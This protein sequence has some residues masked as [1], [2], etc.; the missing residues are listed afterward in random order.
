MN[1]ITL[2][3]STAIVV[4][5]GLGIAVYTTNYSRKVN[6]AFLIS[7]TCM[8]LWLLSNLYIMHLTTASAALIVISIAYAISACIPTTFQL[9]RITIKYPE[10]SWIKIFNTGRSQII[11]N[12]LISSSCF[13]PT[14][15]KSVS[16]PKTDGLLNFAVPEYGPPYI[17]FNIYFIAA[18]I[19]FA[20]G[21]RRD[22]SSLS[23][24]Q[25]IELEFLGFAC[26]AGLVVGLIFG[27]IFAL[28]LESSA[29][30]PIAHAASVLTLAVIVAY[31]ISVHKILAVAV[32][33]RTITAYSLLSC[34]LTAVYLVSWVCF[35]YAFRSLSIQEELPS[36]II[37]TLI[38]AF[39]MAPVR[40]RMQ[41][42]A[43][44][45]IATQAMDVPKAIKQAGN[46]FQS[47]TTI[48]AL[49]EQ[50]SDL[51]KTSLSAENLM[52]L[53]AQ[54][55]SISQTY[56]IEASNMIATFDTES[57]L[58]V[59]ISKD[60]EPVCIDSLERVRQ[61]QLH[62]GAQK[63]L[64]ALGMSIAIGF[65][66]KSDLNGIVM[67]GSR[68]G[69]RIYDR[70]EQE[71]LQILCNQFAVA[72]E[73]AQMYTEM[74]DSKIRNEILLDQLVSGVIVADTEQR[75]TLINHEA[76][77]VT[78]LTEEQA[79]GNEID[80]LPKSIS[81]VLNKTLAQK[82]GQRNL[83][84]AL[85]AQEEES[86]HVRMGSA[87]LHGHDGK[88]MGALLVFTDM[89]ELKKLE[90]QVRRSDQLSSVGTL[91]AGMAHEIK[92]PLVTIKTFSQ[93]LPER[94]ADE[95]FRNDF[96]S[97]VMHE[98]SRIDGI[99]NQL[100]SFSKPTKP[101]LESMKLHD[102]IEQTLKLIHEQLSQKNIVLSNNFNATQDLIS[103]D[104]DLLTQALVNL[105]LNAIDAIEKNGEISVGT[106]NCS[107]RFVHS[108]D[109][110]SSP[111]SCIRLQIS[112]T[113]VGIPYDKLKKIFDPFFTSK[114]EGTGMGLSVAHGIIQ[115]HR[116]V[117]EVES[118]PGKGTTFYIYL[119]ILE[120][121]TAA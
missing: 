98:V 67:L 110:R 95:D 29:P 90:E 75:I 20:Y 120:E 101:H 59:L 42:A 72:L 100:L 88:P 94:Y 91:A 58:S 121:D 119:P 53:T 115:E 89:T 97:L 80:L 86:T 65:Y 85:F 4:V 31:G 52:I 30:V 57:P 13:L 82:N 2:F 39:S 47:V 28:V 61:T 38:V 27:T 73:N 108:N 33:L 79:I 11:A 45:L 109:G 17:L 24:A 34:Y 87:Y 49:L 114:S 1:V 78:G 76:Q 36:H 118:E 37:S 16:F 3:M 63:E 107:Y 60:R 35:S 62:K 55:E 96:S 70:S 6:Q 19:T 103:G 32:I 7:A 26:F 56:P 54:G 106:T 40:G 81:N 43:N 44:K 105:N 51:L 116:G 9:L 84:A 23:G 112:D 99:V 50:F 5:L 64:E 117:I 71:A 74:Q 12:I 48:N 113:G 69:G 21:L 104:A 25:R 22:R 66:S 15:I 68:T 46:I 93:L 14:F 102:T 92:N 83:D 41:N 8:F 10:F 111:T 18:I 77:R